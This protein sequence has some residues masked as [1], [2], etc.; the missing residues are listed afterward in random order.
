[1]INDAIDRP[2]VVMYNLRFEQETFKWT[3]LSRPVL[4]HGCHKVV[5]ILLLYRSS[6]FIAYTLLLKLV[7]MQLNAVQAEREVSY[8]I[9]I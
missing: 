3:S 7:G 5:D 4:Q 6:W 2:V 8:Y 1:M 9:Y